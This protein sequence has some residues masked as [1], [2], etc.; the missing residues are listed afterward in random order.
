MGIMIKKLIP[1]CPIVTGAFL[2]QFS[3]FV[4]REVSSF[5]TTLPTKDADGRVTYLADSW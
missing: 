5:M 2:G 1:V 4:G 3:T